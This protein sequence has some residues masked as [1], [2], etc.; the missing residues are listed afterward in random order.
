MKNK[1]E[2]KGEERETK[3]IGNKSG[4]RTKGEERKYGEKS[5]AWRGSSVS[6][7]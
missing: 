5:K 3:G 1:G 4:R 2:T 6:W 7:D